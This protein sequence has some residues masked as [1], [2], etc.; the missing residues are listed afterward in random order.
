M[1]VFVIPLL[2]VGIAAL[3]LAYVR[4]KRPQDADDA[5]GNFR[6][7]VFVIVFIMYRE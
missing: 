4:H 3:R 6:S 2:L 7:N 5:A 1:R